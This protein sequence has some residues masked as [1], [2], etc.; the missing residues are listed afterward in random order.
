MEPDWWHAHLG[1][2]HDGNWEAI[3]LWAP[4][5]D[6]RNQSARAALSPRPKRSSGATMSGEVIERS[7]AERA[8]CASS[9]CAPAG[10]SFSTP[11]RC[12]RSTPASCVSTC[13]Y[14]PIR[15]SS[16]A[17]NGRRVAMHA[18]RI[19]VRGRAL[20]AFGQ[21]SRQPGARPS[22][23]RRGAEF[24][25]RRAAWRRRNRAARGMLTGYFLKH[26]LPRRLVRWLDIGN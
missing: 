8:A 23:H 2:Y 20:Q 4:G 18:G 7:P 22:G 6:R 15:R 3:A 5:G 19:L 24:R 21:Q 12:T 9:S 17:C 13:R 25:S 11:T 16:S 26:S 10:R 14:A 1:P